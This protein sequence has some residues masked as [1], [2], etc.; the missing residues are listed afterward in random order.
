SQRPRHQLWEQPPAALKEA[1]EQVR[2]FFKQAAATA[3]DDK[4]SV[5]ERSAAARL[6]GYG[7]FATA[8]P[9]LQGLLTP[10]HPSEIQLAAVRALA[11]HD[12]PK[13]AELLLAPWTGY[14]PTVRREVL[15]AL[16]AQ[17]SRVDQL[18]TAIEQKKVLAGQLEP[19]RIEQLR[20]HPNAK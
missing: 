15:E 4:R 19:S 11:L 7:P 1:V 10:Q 14:S 18:L 2:P 5:P 16:F 8:A 12:N 3:Q 13:T 20:K 6:L 17:A 9:A